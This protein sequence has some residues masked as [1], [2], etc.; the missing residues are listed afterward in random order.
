MYILGIKMNNNNSDNNKQKWVEFV[1]ESKINV[2]I[3]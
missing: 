1:I 2:H 3:S